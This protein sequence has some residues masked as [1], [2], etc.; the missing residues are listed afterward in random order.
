MSN[1]TMQRTRL[2]VAAIGSAILLWNGAMAQ[3]TDENQ[4]PTGVPADQGPVQDKGNG[5]AGKGGP[6]KG[7][8]VSFRI[9]QTCRPLSLVCMPASEVFLDI[10][11]G[12][13]IISRQRT[14]SYNIITNFRK[15]WD[16]DVI[17]SKACPIPKDVTAAVQADQC[18]VGSKNIIQLPPGSNPFEFVYTVDWMESNQ[19]RSVTAPLNKDQEIDKR[20]PL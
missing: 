10:V 15:T 1:L 3:P 13:S 18:I 14:S 8:I 9:W 4:A 12:R 20:K 17:S 7:Y 5:M 2:V 16:N 19:S 6:L 11:D